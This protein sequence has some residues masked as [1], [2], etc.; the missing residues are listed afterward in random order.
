MVQRLGLIGRVQRVRIRLHERFYLRVGQWVEQKEGLFRYTPPCLLF[1]AG[2]DLGIRIKL[3]FEELVMRSVGSRRDGWGVLE[4][5][6][7]RGSWGVGIWWILL[8]DFD[9]EYQELM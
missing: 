1:R 8:Y 2:R 5:D 3:L 7:G 4:G 6:L 9:E